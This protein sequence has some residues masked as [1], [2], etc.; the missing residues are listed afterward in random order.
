MYLAQAEDVPMPSSEVK[1][2][3]LLAKEEIHSLCRES[4]TLGQYLSRGGKALLN[5]EFDPNLLLEPFAQLRL[6]SRI[7]SKG[8]L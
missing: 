3:L 7:L 1:G 2:I 8:N 4:L 6:L 5:Y